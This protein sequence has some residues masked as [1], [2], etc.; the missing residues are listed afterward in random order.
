MVASGIR[1]GTPAVTTRG[2][3]LPEMDVIAEAIGR[4][5]E[6]EAP[7]VQQE[8]RRSVGELCAAFPLVA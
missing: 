5:L 4:I 7:E 6:S 3:G 2:M 8:V 1:I